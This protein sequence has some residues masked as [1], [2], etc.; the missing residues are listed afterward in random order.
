MRGTVIGEIAYAEVGYLVAPLATLGVPSG[1]ELRMPETQL[2]AIGV[3]VGCTVDV[4]RAILWRDDDHIRPTVYDPDD[5]SVMCPPLPTAQVAPG[6][7]VINE[8][9]PGFV[10]LFNRGLEPVS[11]GDYRLELVDAHYQ[12]RAQRL[13][14]TIEPWAYRVIEVGGQVGVRLVSLDGTVIDAVLYAVTSAVSDEVNALGEGVPSPLR[15]SIGRCPDHSDT[16]DNAW[17]FATVA[18]PSPGESNGCWW[19]Q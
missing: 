12:L 11:L 8:I 10:E 4:A 1:M 9:G 13:G 17:D 15:G 6:T 19:S 7:I 2:R 18:Y 3:R 14:G 5:V 16:E